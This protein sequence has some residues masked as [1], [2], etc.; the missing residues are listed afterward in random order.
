MKIKRTL[1]IMI[2]S[3]ALLGWVTACAGANG[4]MDKKMDDSM[5]KKMGSDMK[6]K[7][8]TPMDT[9]MDTML[10]GSDGHHAVGMVSLGMG[11]NNGYK[12]TLSDIKVDKVPDGYVYLTKN[13]DRMHAVVLGALKQFSGTVSY[14]LPADV[15]PDDYDT[16]LIWCKKFNVEIGRAKLPHKKM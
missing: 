15:N 12:L 4:M 3:M 2:L 9:P 7:M 6:G 1:S 11:M 16:L 14:E 10:M 13:G 8:E 5:G